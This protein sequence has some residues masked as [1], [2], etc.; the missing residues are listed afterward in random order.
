MNMPVKLEAKRLS[1]VKV[2]AAVNEPSGLGCLV[3]VAR[4]HGLHLTVSQLT[5]DNVLPNRE[6]NVAEIIKCATSVGLKAK[7]VHMDWNGLGSLTK[8]LPVIVRLKTGGSLV[9]RHVGEEEPTLPSRVML[10]DPNAAERRP[11]DHR[12]RALRGSLD[13]GDHA[14]QARL[15]HH[16]RGAAV[17]VWPHRRARV[18]RAADCARRRRSAR[19]CSGFL[20]LGPIVFFMT[21]R[22]G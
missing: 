19:C 22:S 14:H 15:R 10:Q 12:P 4:H 20:A 17:Q 9:L 8:V 7:T 5:H 11:A 13:R 18:P 1:A 16:R 21:L 3:I 6:V 2:E